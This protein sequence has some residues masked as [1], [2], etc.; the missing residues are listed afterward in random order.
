MK[1]GGCTYRYDGTR[2]ALPYLT[3]VTSCN[4]IIHV[5]RNDLQFQEDTI[6]GHLR[7]H[8]R[9]Q[10]LWTILCRRTPEKNNSYC[11]KVLALMFNRCLRF[12]LSGVN[13]LV[14]L[15]DTFYDDCKSERVPPR[16]QIVWFDSDECR[17]NSNPQKELSRFRGNTLRGYENTFENPTRWVPQPLPSEFKKSDRYLYAIKNPSAFI[18]LYPYPSVSATLK[19]ARAGTENLVMYF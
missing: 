6:S 15:T 10:Q 14:F 1:V 12:Q 9:K 17:P 5:G 3:Y 8:I 18:N 13:Y 2:V 16:P 11:S 19:L 7:C 4:A